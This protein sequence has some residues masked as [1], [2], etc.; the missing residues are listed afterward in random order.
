[1][2]RESAKLAAHAPVAQLDRAPGFEPGGR[3]FE[4]V[5]ARLARSPEARSAL[6]QP[7]P[8][9]D[10]PVKARWHPKG[11]RDRISSVEPNF[12]RRYRRAM[13]YPADASCSDHKMTSRLPKVLHIEDDPSVARAVSRLLRIEGYQVRSAGSGEEAIQAV[14]DGLVPDVILADYRLPLETT[15]DQVVAEIATRLGYRPPTIMFASTE[16]ASAKKVMAVADRLFAKPAD[17][18]SV[19]GAIRELLRARSTTAD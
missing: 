12:H 18:F 17:M 2:G 7:F 16:P 11:S 8:A 3:R 10:V 13:D 1:V 19:I 9:F 6:S 4:S 14:A 5:R 15:G